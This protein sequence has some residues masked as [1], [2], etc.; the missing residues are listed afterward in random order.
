M[1]GRMSNWAILQALV[2]EPSKAF[3]AI[4][5]RPRFL[6]PL[7]LL[8][9]ATAGLTA[10][11]LGVVDL[12]WMVDQQLRSNSALARALS[13]EQIAKAAADAGAQR[14]LRATIG[15]LSTGFVLV[16]MSLL[17]ALYYLLAGKITNVDRSFRQWLALNCWSS[18]PTVLAVVPAAFVLLSAGTAQIPQEDLQPLSFNA[19]FFHRAAGEPGFTL[20]SSMNLL[21]LAVLYLAAVGVKTWSGR[22]WLFSWVFAGLPLVLIFGIWAFFAFR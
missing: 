1:E 11:Y 19:L 18:L 9:V 22:S 6:F 13:D 5:E 4:A 21:Q 20:L 17:G 3:A 2:F 14:G 16:L 8:V 15:T 10:W 12:E 7:L